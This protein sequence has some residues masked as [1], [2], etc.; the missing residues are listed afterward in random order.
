MIRRVGVG[1]PAQAAKNE[2]PKISD[3]LT[4]SHTK[5]SG[6]MKM[7]GNSNLGAGKLPEYSERA[8]R[9]SKHVDDVGRAKL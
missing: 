9:G 3:Q 4:A 1:G 6:F 8:P 5:T 7:R 2:R